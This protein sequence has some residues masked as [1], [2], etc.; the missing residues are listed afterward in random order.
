VYQGLAQLERAEMILQFASRGDATPAYTRAQDA[1]KQCLAVAPDDYMCWVELA[2]LHET[3]G[4]YLVNKGGSEAEEILA[5]AREAAEHALALAPA[6]RE[7]RMVLASSFLRLAELRLN[8]GEDPREQLSKA[9]DMLESIRKEDRDLAFHNQSTI[10]FSNWYTFEERIGEDSLGNMDR[11]IQESQA[12]L[13][14][15]DRVFYVWFNLGILYSARAENRRNSEPER[16]LEKALLAYD[17]ARSLNP[18]KRESYSALGKTYVHRARRL[19]D[20]G[21][22]PMPDLMEAQ[23][24]CRQGLTIDPKSPHLHRVRGMALQEQARETWERGG[25]PFPLL[26]QARASIEQALSISPERVSSSIHLGTLLTERARYLRARG[27]DPG[28]SVREAEEVVKRGLERWRDDP[29]LSFIL[30]SVHLIRAGF[31]VDR[32]RAPGPDLVRA[33][34]ELRHALA[35]KPTSGKGTFFQYKAEAWLQLG[36]V[37]ALRARWQARSGKA[38]AEDFEEATKSYEKAIELKP[39]DLEYHL[40]LGQHCS[41]WATWQ[42]QAGREHGSVLK[43]GLELADQILKLRPD[44]KEAQELRANLLEVSQ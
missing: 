40:R 25:N 21:G 30:G 11:A 17:K 33:E 43:R 42:K 2:R 16:D 28:P 6:R 5:R 23:E 34:E 31:N 32:G 7:A 44:W 27:E 36:E 4:L 29:D 18:K 41:T 26:D 10:L 9:A 1:L 37:Q 19:H 38:R 8:H 12:A 35:F 3:N 14:I 20:R 24:Q 39:G 22:D 13:A 15:D